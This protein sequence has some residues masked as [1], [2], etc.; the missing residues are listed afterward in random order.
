[1]SQKSK[2]TQVAGQFLETENVGQDTVTVIT[3]GSQSITSALSNST[4]IVKMTDATTLTLPAPATGLCYKFVQGIAGRN[5]LIAPPAGT[6]ILHGKTVT[7]GTAGTLA[8]TNGT[9]CNDIDFNTT[10]VIG[11]T[12]DV[13]CDGTFYYFDG[14]CTAFNGIVLNN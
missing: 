12:I 14:K 13:V 11:D 3:G 5:I 2:V 4:V 6:N 8:N 9:A 1:M 7:S 10:S